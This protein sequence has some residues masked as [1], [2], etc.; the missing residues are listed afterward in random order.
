[1]LL[2]LDLNYLRNNPT[3]II[4]IYLMQGFADA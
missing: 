2:V 1:M 3:T 4:I